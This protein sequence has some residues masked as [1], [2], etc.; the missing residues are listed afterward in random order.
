MRTEV[1]TS[2]GFLD[3]SNQPIVGGVNR[4]VTIR[5][6]VSGFEGLVADDLTVYFRPYEDATVVSVTSTYVEVVVPSSAITGPIAIDGPRGV[7]YS[8]SLTVNP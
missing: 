2:S 6:V 4:G 5:I 8:P 3:T 7:T 1:V